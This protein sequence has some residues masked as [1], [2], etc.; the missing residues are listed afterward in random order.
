MSQLSHALGTDYTHLTLVRKQQLLVVAHARPRSF[1]L[2]ILEN[3]DFSLDFVKNLLSPGSF[4][5][6]CFLLLLNL[7][8]SLGP[9]FRATNISNTQINQVDHEKSYGL[10]EDNDKINNNRTDKSN[11][12]HTHTHTSEMTT[13]ETVIWPCIY[14]RPKVNLTIEPRKSEQTNRRTIV[15]TKKVCNKYWFKCEKVFP[16]FFFRADLHHSPPNLITNFLCK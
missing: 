8:F 12:T 13:L 14:Y 11:K 10:A 4:W 1:V 5:W 7:D 15:Q 6:Y 3:S 2:S 9:C 16:S